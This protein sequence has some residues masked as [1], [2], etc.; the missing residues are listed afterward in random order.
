MNLKAEFTFELCSWALILVCSIL[1]VHRLAQM[2]LKNQFL[3]HD[4]DSTSGCSAEV[5]NTDS[6]RG[7]SDDGD[8]HQGTN[9]LNNLNRGKG[10]F[11]LV[12]YFVL[13]FGLI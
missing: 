2:S 10:W 3:P 8:N 11:F 13:I 9:Q 1:Q 7:A 6:G 5:S 12:G 4:S